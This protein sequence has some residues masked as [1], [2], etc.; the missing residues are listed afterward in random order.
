MVTEMGISD[1]KIGFMGVK[2]VEAV[3]LYHRGSYDNLRESY[4]IIMEYIE[5][6]GLEITDFPRECYID[7]CWNKSDEK[8]YLTDGVRVR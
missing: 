2:S 3:C 4:S 7:G 1:D 5:K 6:N 8:D